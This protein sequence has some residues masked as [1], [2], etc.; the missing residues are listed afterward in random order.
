MT[1]VNPPSWL[2]PERSEMP[3]LLEVETLC[4]QLD[5]L[6][7]GRRLLSLTVY[8]SKI[9]A[10][11]EATGGIVRNVRRDGKTVVMDFD[12]QRSLLIHLRMT[13]RLF[14]K[15]DGARRPHVRLSLRFDNTDIDLID[16]RRFAT[17]NLVQTGRPALKNDLLT[18]F[19]R[20]LFFKRHAGRRAPVKILLMDPK[21]FAGIGNIYACEILHRAGIEP[22]RPAASLSPGE[23]GKV[24]SRA[25]AVL[26]TAIN[27][28]GT[29]ISDWRDLFGAPGEN[30]TG[31]AVYGREGKR[32]RFCKGV[33][34][35]VKQAGRS[36]YYCPGC[37]K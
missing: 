27:K 15:P 3:E 11:P 37:Q 10:L 6:I 33:V 23:W 30:Q 14:A 18:G 25:R 21:A 34:A 35:R 8:D 12:S 32:C 20:R 28:R 2:N 19:D 13:G 17:V 22:A 5:G 26:K 9:D 31:L 4:R 1:L 29:S 7:R 36:T 24:F 16:P